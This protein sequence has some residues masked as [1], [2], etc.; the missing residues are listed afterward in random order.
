MLNVNNG[1]NYN[2]SSRF[3]FMHLQLIK[4]KDMISTSKK[5]KKDYCHLR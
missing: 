1:T 2:G 3:F 5:K 4:M